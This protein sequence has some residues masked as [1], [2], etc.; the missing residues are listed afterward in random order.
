MDFEKLTLLAE[1]V[2]RRTL[3]DIP[4]DIRRNAGHVPVFLEKMPD[5]ED[6]SEGI[7]DD[8]LGLFDEGDA[9]IPTPRIRLWLE[10]LWEYSDEDEE[11]FCEEVRTTFLHELGHYLGWNEEDLEERGLG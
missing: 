1:E 5:V 10:N 9:L 2:V 3:A 8:T 7:E 11:V 4:A 6:V